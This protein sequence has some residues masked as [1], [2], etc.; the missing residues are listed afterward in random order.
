M[1]EMDMTYD[2][3]P[4]I[5][6]HAWEAFAKKTIGAI[7]KAPGIVEFRA[8]RNVLGTPQVCTTSVWKT[9]AD[10]GHFAQS[11]EWQALEPELRS[12]VTNIRVELWGPSPVV[13]E[14][15]RPGK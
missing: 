3:L 15:L 2:F 5:D 1:I 9:V 14:P 13:P 8:Y 7:L 11:A 4:G 12:F 10:W 6:P